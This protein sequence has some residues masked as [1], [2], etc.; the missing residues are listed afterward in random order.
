[1]TD[2]GALTYSL[3][4]DTDGT[5]LQDDAGELTPLV[6]RAYEILTKINQRALDASAGGVRESELRAILVDIR[7]MTHDALKVR[8]TVSG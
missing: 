8:E 1:M 2:A 5:F 6:P 7:N 3:H 4:T